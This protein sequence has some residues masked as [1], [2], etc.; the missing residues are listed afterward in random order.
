M[1]VSQRTVQNQRGSMDARTWSA[2]VLTAGLSLR[3]LVW[4]CLTEGAAGIRPDPRFKPSTRRL[5]DLE[6]HIFAW[7][8]AFKAPLKQRE[9]G[10]SLFLLFS[11]VFLSLSKKCLDALKSSFWA[12]C[13]SEF[14]S[15]RHSH[16]HCLSRKCYI[17]LCHFSSTSISPTSGHG[18][19]PAEVPLSGR[20]GVPDHLP[21]AHHALLPHPAGWGPPVPGLLSCGGGRGH[22]DPG[23]CAAG[24]QGA[25]LVYMDT[26]SDCSTKRTLSYYRSTFCFWIYLH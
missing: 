10:E 1:S 18:F 14:S 13:D 20:V 12:R 26:S 15:Q 5:F 17:Y 3:Y 2:A 23:L 4:V 24:L 11:P 22:E 7:G 9:T 8:T 19:I 21:G 25:R 6:T 16:L